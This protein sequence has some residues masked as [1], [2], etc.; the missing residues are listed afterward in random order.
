MEFSKFF[1]GE[2]PVPPEDLRVGVLGQIRTLRGMTIQGVADNFRLT[3]LEAQFNTHNELFNRRLRQREEGATGRPVRRAASGANVDAAAG[4][5]LDAGLEASAVTAL[6]RGL[7][8]DS[9]GADYDRFREYLSNQVRAIR[10][11]TGC[12]AV[13]FRVASEDGRL[14]LKARPVKEEGGA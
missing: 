2:R 10:D 8:S 1:G 14:K 11:K 13:V 5:R 3:N 9:E 12:A 7:Y 4:V 6:Y